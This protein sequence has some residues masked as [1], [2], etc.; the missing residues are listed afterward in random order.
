MSPTPGQPVELF[1]QDLVAELPAPPSADLTVAD[2]AVGGDPVVVGDPVVAAADPDPAVGGPGVEAA[3]SPSETDPVVEVE[4][5]PLPAVSASRRIRRRRRRRHERRLIAG[6]VTGAAAAVVGIAAVAGA[7]YAGPDVVRQVTRSS[8]SP[9][10]APAAPA[11]SLLVLQSATHTASSVMVVAPGPGG[12]GGRGG[13][14]LLLEPGTMAE[15]PSMG[16]QPLAQT[17]AIGGPD[18]MRSTL[19]NLL[20]VGFGEV[21]VMDEAGLVRLV[22][23]AAPLHVDV[24]EAVEQVQP[25]GLVTVVFPAGP[26]DVT[27]AQVPVLLGTP[28]PSGDLVRLARQEA[29]LHAWMARIRQDPGVMAAAAPGLRAALQAVATTGPVGAAG[30]VRVL[31]VNSVGRSDDGTELYQV[32]AAQAAPV[33]AQVFPGVKPAAG[34]PSVQILNGTGALGLAQRVTDKLLPAGVQV[35]LTDNAGRLNYAQ[36]QVVYYEAAQAAVAQRIR[37]ALGVG[38]LVLSRR[39]IDVVDVTVIVGKDFPST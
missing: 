19:Q 2:P 23:A 38:T 7:I 35:K 27:A 15:V 39:P 12:V 17:L 34:R 8:G 37:N 20:G 16:L 33:E 25:G 24:P 22:Q 13:A 5:I 21:D 26:Q 6:T 9:A 28:G 30:N 11:P 10:A 3:A 31:P 32:D 29:F 1:D 14:V 18:R 4:P 36:T